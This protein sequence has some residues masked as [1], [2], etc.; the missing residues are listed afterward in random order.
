MLNVNKNGTDLQTV[1]EGF[2]AEF[3]A[4]NQIGLSY[5]QSTYLIFSQL[6]V[7]STVNE[8]KKHELKAQQ[9][10]GRPSIVE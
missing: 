4:S 3:Y 1:P 8:K 2:P 9:T 6:D 7:R 10:V 5:D